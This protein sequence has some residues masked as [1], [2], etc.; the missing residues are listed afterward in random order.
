MPSL[1]IARVKALASA[2]ISPREI[3]H[4][5]AASTFGQPVIAFGAVLLM[6][7]WGGAWLLM[8]EDSHALRTK[9]ERDA[10]NFARVAQQNA[11]GKIAQR[12]RK[13]ALL[14]LARPPR[15]LS[16][17]LADAVRRLPT[18]RQR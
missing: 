7:I 3:S 11:A 13:A 6:M 16:R 8:F 1:G 4:H 17:G 18:A 12:R 2:V 14:A 10:V 15:G 9:A 5:K